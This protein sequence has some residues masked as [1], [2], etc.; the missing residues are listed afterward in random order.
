MCFC[1]F[2]FIVAVI[3]GL[4]FLP[5]VKWYNQER[6]MSKYVHFIEQASL[7]KDSRPG[8]E[9]GLGP[10]CLLRISQCESTCGVLFQ[11]IRNHTVTSEN[12]SYE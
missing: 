11:S 6:Q 9:Q 12:F 3:F 4:L 5:D 8:R 1:L 10:I 2:V 7:E